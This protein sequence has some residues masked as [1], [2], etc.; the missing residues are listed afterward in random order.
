MAP[1]TKEEVML[2]GQGDGATAA[3]KTCDSPWPRWAGNARRRHMM[4]RTFILEED[5][6][7]K[8]FIALGP[9]YITPLLP[10]PVPSSSLRFFNN[11]I[12]VLPRNWL[13]SLFTLCLEDPLV[14]IT[15]DS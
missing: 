12:F 2:I 13:E 8:S 6:K 4:P 7:E 15:L 9:W 3:R 10:R 11:H 5:L 14:S 1:L